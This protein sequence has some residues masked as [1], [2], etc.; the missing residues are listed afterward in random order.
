MKSAVYAACLFVLLIVIFV[1][2]DR[3]DFYFGKDDAIQEK[4]TSNRSPAINDLNPL[5]RAT[6]SKSVEKEIY[7]TSPQTDRDNKSTVS[8]Q[9]L[10]KEETSSLTE[11]DPDPEAFSPVAI[12]VVTAEEAQALNQ[13][14]LIYAVS[15]KEKREPFYNL[16]KDQDLESIVIQGTIRDIS[17]IPDPAKN[18]YPNCLYSLFIEFNSLLTDN[19]SNKKINSEAII[20]VPIIKEKSILESNRLL[21]GNKVLCTCVEYDSMPQAI[22]EIQISDD[23]QSFEHQQYYVT[24][25]D[26]ITDFLPGGNKDFAKREI[27]VLPIHQLPEDDNARK[28]RTERI[29]SEIARI[30]N[31]LQKHG[32]SF[33]SWRKEYQ[34]IAKKYQKLC[35]ERYKGW[36]KGSYFSASGK[37][38]TYKTKEY[39]EWILPYKKFLENNNI[40][41][42]IL[43][44]PSRADFAARVLAAEDF[45]EN[46]DWIEHYYEC[47]KN[48]IEIVDP[49]YEMWNKRFDYPLFYF[50]TF[51]DEE[52]H[53]FEGEFMTAAETI[54]QVLSRYKYQKNKSFS[55]KKMIIDND[56]RFCWSEENHPSFIS[57]NYIEFDGLAENDEVVGFLKVNTGSPFLFLSNSMFGFKEM[58]EKGMSVPQYTSF[59]L[60]STVD[61]KFQS[62]VGNP[63]LRNLITDATNLDQRSAVIM[64][65]QFNLWTDG[66]KIPKYLFDK[67]DKISYETQHNFLSQDI[68]ISNID[69]YETIHEN[70][71]CLAV[72]RASEATNT[73]SSLSVDFSIPTPDHNYNTCMIRVNFRKISGLVNLD[74]FGNEE[75]IDA[76]TLTRN[77]DLYADFYVPVSDKKFRFVFSSG[78]AVSYSIE[79]IEFWYY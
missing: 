1:V 48:D 28:L 72:S 73:H 13:E 17:I 32:G 43:R 36:I 52:R 44:C 70:D 18:D 66:P 5:N 74:L 8:R 20:L 68:V 12:S 41:L 16:Y 30:E 39:I 47:L 55:L 49:M 78:S 21:P 46:P 4:I 38:S 53:P 40:D 63:M 7:G 61:W 50:Y 60:Q 14:A 11:M 64:V 71:G 19:S 42:I 33:S 76:T 10:L 59:F 2:I 3:K 77:S 69:S 54:S 29:Q 51:P 75:R 27:T 67:T 23:I 62:G 31:E 37:E 25:L 24:R 65:G 6:H 58:Q 34:P 57:G 15:Q 22:Q 9:G 45:Q 26:L 79:N 56:K 35:D